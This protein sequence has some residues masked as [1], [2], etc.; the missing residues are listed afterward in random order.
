MSV[1]FVSYLGISLGSINKPLGAL[2][3]SLSLKGSKTVERESS[4]LN[5]SFPILESQGLQANGNLLELIVFND[6]FLNKR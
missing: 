1:S 2:L 4:F 5:L 6:L 3:H